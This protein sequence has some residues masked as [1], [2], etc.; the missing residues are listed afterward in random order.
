[1]PRTA[2]IIVEN[3]CYHLIN[4]GNNRSLIFHEHEDYAAFI[5]LMR[6]AQERIAVPLLAACLMPNHVHFV[7]RP[8]AAGDL[9]RWMH[10]LFTTHVRHFH[11]K[12][13]SSGRVWQD[14]FK[15]FVIQEDGHLLTVMRYVE[16]NAMRAGLVARAE[17][18]NWGSLKWRS[19]SFPA[20]ELTA[21]P[22]SLPKDWSDYV[23]A[24][25]TRT[26]LDA[27]RNC[28]NRQRPFGSERWAREAAEKLG[29]SCSTRY[30]R[31]PQ[32]SAW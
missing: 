29:L 27:L 26:E 1:M 20:L 2:R 17:D 4:R 13:Q 14:R 18:W 22:I 30:G 5:A 16:R 15:A 7:V 9:A 10:W 19:S 6:Q 23:N 32:Q 11:A 3:H 8:T 12:Y 28:V 31:R 21:A 25:Q 24:A